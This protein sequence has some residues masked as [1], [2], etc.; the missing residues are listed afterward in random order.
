MIK[1]GTITVSG[2]YVGDGSDITVEWSET[3]HLPR[4]NESAILH[5][6]D[7]LAVFIEYQN[8]DA[9]FNNIV[10]LYDLSGEEYALNMLSLLRLAYQKHGGDINDLPTHLSKDDTYEV[11]TD[12]G[13]LVNDFSFTLELMDVGAAKKL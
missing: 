9:L 2:D 7:D 10:K 3:Y 11:C 4:I 6:L 1:N 13:E 8:E 5:A 12:L